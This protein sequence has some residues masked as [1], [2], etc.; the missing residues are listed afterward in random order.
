MRQLNE[1]FMKLFEQNDQYKALLKC[2]IDD[3]DLDMQIRENYLNV[4]YKG[5]S[6][7]KIKPRSFDID[8]MYFFVHTEDGKSST[9]VKKDNT[10]LTGLKEKRN[11]L[12]SLLPSFPK[13][14]FRQAKEVMDVWDNALSEKVEHNEKKEQ[15][16]IILANSKNTEYI[17]LDVEYAVSRNSEFNYVKTAQIKKE[18]PRFDII[19]IHNGRLVVI[20]LKK[21]LGAVPGTSGVKAHMD[22]FE[23]TIG[24]DING[25]FIKEMRTLLAQKKALG[26]LDEIVEIKDE[27]PLFMF[28]FADEKGKDEFAGFVNKCREKRYEGEFIYL[29]NDHKLRRREL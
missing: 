13:E 12:L 5:G 18:V 22:C 9:D 4:Y 21:G 15:Q 16:Q 8:K 27:K 14:Y 17:V 26:L 11:K 29:G 24:Q 10:V 3:P 2:I 23:Y 1:D 7:L 28:A 6:I 25:V 19:A 20:E